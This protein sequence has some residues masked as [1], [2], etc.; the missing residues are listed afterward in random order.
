MRKVNLIFNH[1]SFS[2]RP[3][4][5]E[6]C[7]LGDRMG[8]THGRGGNRIIGCLTLA[9]LLLEKRRCY[10]SFSYLNYADIKL[11]PARYYSARSSLQR[12]INSQ[13]LSPALQPCQKQYAGDVSWTQRLG[14]IVSLAKLLN[15]IRSRT[16]AWI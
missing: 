15:K 6:H 3:H 10:L 9:V 11:S 8:H 12:K 16:T 14:F 13:N 5:K 1:H 2:T 4:Q 7:R